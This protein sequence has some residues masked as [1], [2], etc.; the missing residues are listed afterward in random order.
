M[1]HHSATEHLV[2]FAEG[3]LDGILLRDMTSHIDGCSDCQDWLEVHDFLAN[4]TSLHVEDEHPSSNIIAL[5]A[6]RAEE[7]FELDRIDLHEHLQRCERCGR[8][9]ELLRA[10][11]QQ[12]RPAKDSSGSLRIPQLARTA[13]WKVAAAAGFLG[14]AIGTLAGSV[15]THRESP[16]DEPMRIAKPALVL[17]LGRLGPPDRKISDAEIEG[18]RLIETDGNLTISETRIKAGADVTIHARNTV[19]FGNGFEIGPRARMAV[20]VSQ[21]GIGKPNPG[22]KGGSSDSG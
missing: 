8:E 9:I 12:A 14:V 1:N 6:V 2:E 3:N 19:A 18:E 13:R 10:A 17:P 20:Q 22:R 5:C 4:A 11:I 16:V 15:A 21:D 7:E